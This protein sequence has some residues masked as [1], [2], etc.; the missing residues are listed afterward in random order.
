MNLMGLFLIFILNYSLINLK[1]LMP[2]FDICLLTHLQ[3][4][5][6]ASYISYFTNNFEFQLQ[7]YCIIAISVIR[8]NKLFIILFYIT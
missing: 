1:S 8:T 6:H 5:Y 3:K 4:E 7:L 2:A